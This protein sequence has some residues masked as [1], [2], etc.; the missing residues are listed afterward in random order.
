MTNQKARLTV[1]PIQKITLIVV[2][3]CILLFTVEVRA[4]DNF[5]PAVRTSNINRTKLNQEPRRSK[6]KKFTAVMKQTKLVPAGSWGGSGI[7]LIVEQKSVKIEYA[8]ADGEITGRLKTDGQGNFKVKGFHTRVRPG[9]IRLDEK[10][11]R[12]PAVFEGKIS[13][14]VMTLVVILEETKE[15]IGNFELKQN[16]AP[17][18][19]RCL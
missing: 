15:V 13:S 12:R 1:K 2:Y 11:E 3:V 5:L 6:K 7:R 8:C 9:P 10:P 14:R 4:F 17:R 16:V 18:L 19:F